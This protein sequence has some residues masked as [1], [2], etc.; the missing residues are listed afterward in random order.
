M[1]PRP[2]QIYDGELEDVL[3]LSMLFGY[4][5]NLLGQWSSERVWTE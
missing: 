4:A 2:G 5:W 1:L 3:R